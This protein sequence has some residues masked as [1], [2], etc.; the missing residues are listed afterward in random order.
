MNSFL[1]R[2][3]RK[4]QSFMKPHFPGHLNQHPFFMSSSWPL[5]SLGWLWLW[6]PLPLCIL[7]SSSWNIPWKQARW[8]L[9][10]DSYGKHRWQ[11]NPKDLFLVKELMHYDLLFCTKLMNWTLEIS[12]YIPLFLSLCG[13]ISTCKSS[14][15]VLLYS[16]VPSVSWL[17]ALGFLIGRI[18]EYSCL[19]YIIVS[20]KKCSCWKR[21]LFWALKARL[22][23]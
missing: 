19:K 8:A 5:S 22:C 9:W 18:C 3:L 10:G 4:E 2:N 1:K 13:S 7:P 21:P 15:R 23:L 14:R 16:L 6:V 20:F 11:P 17:P 12:W